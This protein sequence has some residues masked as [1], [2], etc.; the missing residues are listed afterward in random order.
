MLLIITLITCTYSLIKL[1]GIDELN[2]FDFYFNYMKFINVMFKS[3]HYRNTSICNKKCSSLII[4]N[5]LLV[6]LSVLTTVLYYE[7]QLI[8]DL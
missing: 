8:C 6:C 2:R 4:L 1:H 7:Q 3:S 5:N